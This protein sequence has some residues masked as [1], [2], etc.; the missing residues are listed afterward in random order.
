ML[1]A[2]KAFA[3]IAMKNTHWAT[4]VSV[5]YIFWLFMKMNA[6]WRKTQEMGLGQAQDQLKRM[7]RW[8]N[9]PSIQ[10]WD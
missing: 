7:L 6:K 1:E 4:S 9:N 2:R 5:N 3:S 8:W 10:C